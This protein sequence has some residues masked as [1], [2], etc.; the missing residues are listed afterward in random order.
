MAA[1]CLLKLDSTKTSPRPGPVW[2]KARVVVTWSPNDRWYC[3]PDR[4]AATLLTPY[5]LR[6]RS[7]FSSVMGSS[8]GLTNPYSSLE[9]AIWIFVPRSR[10]LTAS[11]TFTVPIVLIISVSDGDCQLVGTNDWAAKWKMWVGRMLRT[12]DKTLWA[13]VTS[14]STHCT[15]PLNRFSRSEERRVGKECRSRWWRY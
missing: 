7:G 3:C 10:L 9:P 14:I 2:L 12:V 1:I 8:S 6:G 11:R 15:L 13:S 4:S 5:G